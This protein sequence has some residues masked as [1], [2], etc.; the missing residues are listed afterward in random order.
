[1]IFEKLKSIEKTIEGT[2]YF[3]N[4]VAH[5]FSVDKLDITDSLQ[6]AIKQHLIQMKAIDPTE[7]VT[8]TLIDNP[9]N[10][11]KTLC[12]EWHFDKSVIAGILSIVDGTTKVYKCCEDFEYIAI[13]NVGD[14]FRILVTKQEIVFLEFYIVD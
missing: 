2:E 3:T 7:N 5:Y 1:M 9:Q 4:G 8:L 6:L 11:I 13:G 14:I 12:D 10:D